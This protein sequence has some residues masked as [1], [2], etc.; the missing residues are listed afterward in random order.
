MPVQ[1][2]S[3]Q[4][5]RGACT[6]PPFWTEQSTESRMIFSDVREIRP[7]HGT[8]TLHCICIEEDLTWNIFVCGKAVNVDDCSV[9]SSFGK[10]LDCR[11]LSALIEVVD[12]SNLCKGNYEDHFVSLVEMRKGTIRTANGAVSAY[13]DDSFPIHVGDNIHS[14][15][16]RSFHCALL[17]NQENSK[18]QG[19]TTYR[20]NLRAIHARHQKETGECRQ[21]R[22]EA[23][24]HTNYR[25]LSS[26][27]KNAR[28]ANLHTKT[29]GLCRQVNHLQNRIEQ[30]TQLNGVDLDG[31]VDED[32]RRIMNENDEAVTNSYP[33]ES[34]Q[35]LFWRQQRECMLLKNSKQMR[36]H[37]MLIKWC[38][39]L[40]MLSSSTYNSLRSAGVLHLPSE[41]T[42]RDYTNIIK[43][44]PGFQREVDEQLAKEAKVQESPDHQKYVAVIFDEVK[45]K[46][47]LVYNKHSG[48][49]IGFID[50]TDINNHLAAFEE[51]CR[52]EVSGPCLATHMLVFMVRGLFSSLQFPYAQFP[53][54]TTSGDVINPIVWECIEHLE[55]IGLKV[56]ALVCDGAS[57][58]R[59][60]FR[61]H[62]KP[63]DLT[64]KVTNIYD[65]SRSIFFV[66]DVPHLLKTTR[67]SWANSYAHS[68]SRKLWVRLFL[69]LVYVQA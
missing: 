1:V 37:P 62:G 44:K 55:L 38:I 66:S 34:F 7:E 43:S 49:L 64:Y 68:N 53:V 45:I 15:T 30:L 60:F 63:K 50:I 3:L 33:P 58:N 14:K 4:S 6:L 8:E 41:R 54:A 20:S 10:K 9:L 61:M 28:L 31:T 2:P 42:L 47:D 69:L 51:H 24:S 32:M 17:T 52:N 22:V 26:P 29:K 39:H 27:E 46:E 35:G 56:L 57:P 13:L 16:V 21:R 18:C 25:Y 65:N 40:R 23:D 48:E 36:W 19:C 59:K 12:G 5:L 67:N 11:S